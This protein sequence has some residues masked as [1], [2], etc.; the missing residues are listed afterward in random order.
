VVL[1]PQGG[2]AVE[3]DGEPGLVPEGEDGPG[4]VPEEEKPV[5]GGAVPVLDGAY[6]VVV[7]FVYGGEEVDE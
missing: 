5:C 6:G 1:L 3:E 7:V 4:T 2:V